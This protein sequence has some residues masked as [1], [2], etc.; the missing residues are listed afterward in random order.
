MLEHPAIDSMKIETAVLNH[1]LTG[2]VL[3]RFQ[4][5][6]AFGIVVDLVF[7]LADPVL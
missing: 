7:R 6:G 1:N 5:R 3:V 4:Q 2:E